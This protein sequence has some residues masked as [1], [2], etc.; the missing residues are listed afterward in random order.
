ML[1]KEITLFFTAL[2]YFTRIPCPSHV[3]HNPNIM[4]KSLRYLPLVGWLVGSLSGAILVI[5]NRFLTTPIASVAGIMLAIII[6][7]A[8]HEDGLADTCDGFGGGWNKEQILK[9]MKDSRIGSFGGIGICFALLIKFTAISELAS[10]NINKTAMI[11]ICAHA[12][13]RL[14]IIVLKHNLLYVSDPENAKSSPFNIPFDTTGFVIAMALGTLP[15]FLFQA[16]IVWAIPA[17]LVL[18]ILL[19][20]NYFKKWI[21]GYTGDC[22]GAVQQITEIFI[23]LFFI[24]AWKYI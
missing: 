12:V 8:I 5:S 1:K 19:M 9:I 24:P 14:A 16:W 17:I 15:L 23:Y 6:T 20:K 7:G 4:G 11:I 22:L 21:G 10:R 3:Y 18:I 13:S 2:Q